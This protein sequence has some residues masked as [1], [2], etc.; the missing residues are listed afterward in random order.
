MKKEDIQNYDEMSKFL[1]DNGW[2]DL[3]HPDNW[4]KTKWVDN[5]S[6]DIDVVG[7]SIQQAY[8]SCLKQIEIKKFKKLKK[9]ENR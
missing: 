3:L 9:N 8:K 1:K 6:I 2:T 7:R 4:V 5:P